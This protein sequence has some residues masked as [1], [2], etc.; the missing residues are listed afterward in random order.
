MK[1][2]DFKDKC[3]TDIIT[4]QDKSKKWYDLR[5]GQKIYG[6]EYEM[7][8]KLFRGKFCPNC[9][10]KLKKEFM[11]RDKHD[12]TNHYIFKCSCGYK[13]ADYWHENEK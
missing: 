11:F 7:I 9:D 10:S 2:E 1:I 4:D 3:L 6:H 8:Y 13:Y 12:G 5:E